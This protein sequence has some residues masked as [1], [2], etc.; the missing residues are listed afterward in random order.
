VALD[1]RV[2]GPLIRAAGGVVWRPSPDL[3]GEP[4]GEPPIELAVVHRPR[5]DDWCLPKGKLRS[6]ETELDA[7]IREVLEETG[8]HVRVGDP[9]GRTRYHRVVNGEL[10]P[11]VVHWWAM[12]AVAGTFAPSD[13]IDAIRWV[14]PDL[15]RTILSSA[16]DLTA[17]QRFTAL[18]VAPEPSLMR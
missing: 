9:L 2:S 15:A 12:E 16:S 10:R 7:A 18:A 17:L 5:Y 4:G 1:G 6:G 3:G 11:K 13:E 14:S 8:C